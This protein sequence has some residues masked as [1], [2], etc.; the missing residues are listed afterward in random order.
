MPSSPRR[1]E[2]ARRETSSQMPAYGTTAIRVTSTPGA[3]D[4][5]RTAPAS[6]VTTLKQRSNASSLRVATSVGLGAAARASPQRSRCA[7]IS[8]RRRLLVAYTSSGIPTRSAYQRPEPLAA[9]ATELVTRPASPTDF[10]VSWGL[11]DPRRPAKPSPATA[12]SIAGRSQMKSRYASAP[13][14]IPPPV[15]TSRST[16]SNTTSTDSWRR[17]SICARS[18]RRCFALRE[19]LR[20]G[21]E[22]GPSA[23]VFPSRVR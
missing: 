20:P 2:G 18:V 21:L 23:S 14:M 8:A 4:A 15:S 16:T 3:D 7:P 11:S 5:A 13:A 1:D 22:R 6:A 17:R 12:T 10:A 19:E 9:L